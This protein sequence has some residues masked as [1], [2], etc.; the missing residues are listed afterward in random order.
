MNSAPKKILVVDDDR[1]IQKAAVQVLQKSGYEVLVAEDGPEAAT[2]ARHEKPDLILLDLS[3][4][5]DPMSGPLS[6]GFE[7]VQWLRKMPESQHIPIV[8]ISNT[9]AAEYKDRF[10]E[11]EIVGF[12]QKPLGKKEILS[13]IEK[14][15]AQ[16]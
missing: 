7:V 13:A 6:N 11:G 8:I 9:P 10:Y 1:V 4:P 12:Y 2:V 16:K 5:L 14:A 3:F 15:L